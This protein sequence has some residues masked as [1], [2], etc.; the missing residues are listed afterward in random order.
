LKTI[1]LTIDGREI[2]TQQGKSILDA[3][4]EAGIYIPHLC[5]HP[6]LHPIGVCRLCVV[7]IE[8]LEGLRT[9]CTTSASP[10]MVIRTKSADIDESRR[11]SLELMLA[12]HQADCGACVKYLNCELQ[13]IK[14]YFLIDKLRVARRSRLFGL[15]DTNPIFNHEPNKCILCGRCVRACHELR[16]AGVL[17]YKKRGEETYIGVGPD[18]DIPLAEAGCRFCGACAEVCP[19]GAILDKYEF[20]QDKSK[21]EALLPCSATCPAGIDVPRYIRLIRAKN[22]SAAN[23][24]IR[25]KVP[26]PAVLGYVCNHACESLCRRGDVNEAISIRDL[27]RFAAEH[28]TERLWEKN[29]EQ[30][31][32]TGKKVAVIGSGPA[33]LT[34]A[35]FLTIQGHSVTVFEELPQPGG[36]LRYGIP[37]YRLPR[38]VIDNEIRDIVRLGVDLRTNTRVENI[39]D[40]FEEEYEAVLI[41]V[42]THQGVRL[43]IP[44]SKGEGVLINTEFLRAVNLGEPVEVGRKVMVLGG[45]NVAFDCARLALRLGAETV[46]IACLESRETMPADADELKEGEE[47]GIKI[48]PSR[49]FTKIV[50]DANDKVKGVEFQKVAAFTFDEEKRLHLE[51]VENSQHVVEADTVIFAVGQRPDLPGG[52]GV[53][54]TPGGFAEIDSLSMAT[55]REGVYAAADCVTGT[56]FVIKAIDSGRKA[57]IAIDKYLGGRGKIDRK[58][59]P[60]TEPEKY[61]GRQEGFA[62]LARAEGKFAPAKE[63]VHSFCKVSEGMDEKTAEYEANRC[64]RC[65]LR[66]KMTQI[67]FWSNY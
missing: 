2:E 26:F 42:G 65:D 40:L 22:Y 61:L 49:A 31:P 37:S 21:K 47:E 57:A 34:A 62:S 8:G 14:Q 6:D 19:T 36:M 23:A 63:R 9:S 3:S 25:E 15:T 20:G 50:R 30:K 33:G 12:G 16:G 67:E 48:Y 55:S 13:S 7:E 29:L 41:A 59:A 66:L 1:K 24:V 4:L 44:G 54:K 45:G 64:L 35:Y 18:Q 17:Y 10:G 32:E 5:H 56:S 58:L 39:D 53:D 43:R 52:F 11:L 51:T 60:V 46:M 27:K 38:E 28:D